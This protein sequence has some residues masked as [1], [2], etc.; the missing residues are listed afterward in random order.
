MSKHLSERRRRRL[1]GRNFGEMTGEQPDRR[2]PQRAGQPEKRLRPEASRDHRADDHAEN[3]R[4]AN[5][6]AQ[7]GHRGRAPLGRDVIGNRG[8]RR[9]RDG[10]DALHEASKNEL[11][12]LKRARKPGGNRAKKRTQAED[13]HAEKQH[14]AA[15]DPV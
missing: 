8:E 2:K 7:H 1:S 9:G 3:E 13:R 15:S 14:L 11:A 12:D 4:G 5:R 6:D 10:P